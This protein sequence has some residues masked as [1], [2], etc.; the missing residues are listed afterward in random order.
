[1]KFLLILAQDSAAW[2]NE[3]QSEKDRTFNE[4]MAVY[5]DLES[6]K[7]LIDSRR[8]RP[9]SEAVTLRMRDGK[10]IET[11]GSFT[12]TPAEVGGLYII[13]CASLEEAVGWARKMP[14]FGDARYAAIEVRP[15]WE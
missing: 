9:S 15:I 7:K 13:D 2:E 6:Q 11:K 14:H 4:H 3:P 8:L 12:G 1:M 5:S 10:R